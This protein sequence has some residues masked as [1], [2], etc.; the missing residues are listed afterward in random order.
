M[1]T[2][3]NQPINRMVL[4]DCPACSAPV[5][6]AFTTDT[7]ESRCSVC[8]EHI[9][10]SVKIAVNQDVAKMKLVGRSFASR[11]RIT[12]KREAAPGREL[13]RE[14]WKPT[15]EGGASG[16]L[17]RADCVRS[18]ASDQAEGIQSINQGANTGGGA[19]HNNFLHSAFQ[20][21]PELPPPAVW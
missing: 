14:P 17:P 4:W 6:V 18:F 21:I 16:I 8:R 1:S 12:F 2:D 9:T 20:P 7:S 3:S 10:V 13:A 19:V 11:S 15:S 5:S